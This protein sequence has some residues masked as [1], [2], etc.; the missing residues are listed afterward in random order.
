[1][2][3]RIPD[4]KRRMIEVDIVLEKPSKDITKAM[5]VSG[6]LVQRFSTNMKVHDSLAPPK[7]VTHG[8]PRVTVL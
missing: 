7:V 1:M 5:N 6:R 4:V 3:C 2:P 8:Q